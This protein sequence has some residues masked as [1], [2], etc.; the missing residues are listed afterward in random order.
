MDSSNWRNSTKTKSLQKLPYI[1]SAMDVTTGKS[2]I[3]A[4]WAA[5]LRPPSAEPAFVAAVFRPPSFLRLADKIISAKR[6]ANRS[7][8]LEPNFAFIQRSG[9]TEDLLLAPP[10][11]S[12]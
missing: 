1:V 2:E 7:H 8:H 3:Q 10:S 5:T 6:Q 11:N 9:A 12:L 4:E